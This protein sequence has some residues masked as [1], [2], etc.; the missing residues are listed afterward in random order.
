MSKKRLIISIGTGAV[1]GI[2][3]II[4]V[5]IR[6]GFEGNELF[7][8]TSWIN[9]III[10]LAIGLAPYYNIKNNI[11]HKLKCDLIKICLEIKNEKNTVTKT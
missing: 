11:N 4:G 7:I 1:L 6:L 8:F 10:G 3:C 9:R 2:F 5:T